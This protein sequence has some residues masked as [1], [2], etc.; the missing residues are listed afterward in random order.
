MTVTNAQGDRFR[1]AR[2]S[3]KCE[4]REV[5]AYLY[6]N[7]TAY[8]NYDGTVMIEG[9]DRQGFTMDALIDRLASGLIPAQEV[10]L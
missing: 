3:K 10:V 5:E 7:F 9:Y 1:R 2:V 8:N 6:S 4:L